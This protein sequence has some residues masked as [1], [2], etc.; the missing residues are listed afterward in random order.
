MHNC[1]T[2]KEQLIEVAMGQS[3]QSSPE[4]EELKRCP[5]CREELASL[6]SL[7]RVTDQTMA[8]TTPAE[9][10]WPPYHAR[11]EQALQRES[12][13]ALR[14]TIETRSRS[15]LR[16]FFTTSIRIPIPLAAILI[17][18]FGLSIVF[19][20]HSRRRA[21]GMTPTVTVLTKT[22]EVP[23]IQN[24]TITRIVYRE[25]SRRANPDALRP[26]QLARNR[27]RVTSTSDDPPTSLV[28]FKPTSDPKLTIIKGS[29]RDEK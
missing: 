27:S 9:K 13:P 25:K 24:R 22:V 21:D 20:A 16:S 4:L 23:V 15:R 1:K 2:T 11:L 10:F 28:G 19:A 17:V 7:F 26:E 18:L 12:S 6:R 3:R 14:P 29:Y 5:A 8:S